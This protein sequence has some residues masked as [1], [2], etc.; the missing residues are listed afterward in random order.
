MDLDVPVF[1]KIHQGWYIGGDGKLIQHKNPKFNVTSHYLHLKKNIY[2]CKQAACNWFKLLL[3]G[4]CKI[5]F[6]QPSTDSC[7]FLFSDCIIAVYVD[8]C[9]F[10]SPDSES[11]DTVSAA[12]LQTF[13]LKDEG[14][15][16]A[17]LGIKISKNTETKTI[18][19]TQPGLIDQ[20]IRD[21]RTITV[22]RKGKDNPADSI[23]EPDKTGPNRVED[24]ISHSL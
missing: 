8:D 18:P 23:L 7:L 10:F 1:I 16:S 14:D 24:W 13:K 9:L 5:V 22:F 2:G 11:I 12:L 19:L 15:I 3:D 17:F 20:K 6:V 4:L 21:I